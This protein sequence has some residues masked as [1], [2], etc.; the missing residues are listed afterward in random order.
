MRHARI[1][2]DRIAGFEPHSLPVSP[3]AGGIQEPK[4]LHVCVEV[5]GLVQIAGVQRD[6]ITRDRDNVIINPHVAWYSEAAMVGLQAG[7]PSEVR[8]VLTGAWPVNVVNGAVKG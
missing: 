7:A 8:R 3:R 5:A 4:R 1:E 6:E 2:V